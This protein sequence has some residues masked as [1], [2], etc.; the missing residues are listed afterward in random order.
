VLINIGS[1]VSDAVIPYQDMYSASGHAVKDFADVLRV[2]W[3]ELNAD[4]VSV[5]LI[6]S[7]AVNTPYL[8]T[9][10]TTWRN[11]PSCRRL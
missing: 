9:R 6:Q 4:A 2:E 3:N 11:N 1:E 8:S 7:T 10:T 5:T